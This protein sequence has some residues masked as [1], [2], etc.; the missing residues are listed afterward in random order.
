M[1]TERQ[2]IDD[3][4]DPDIVTDPNVQKVVVYCIKTCSTCKTAMKELEEAGYGVRY[5]DV[6]GQDMGLEDW[7]HLE[8][9]VG[10][11]ALVNTK[12]QTWRNL[13]EA[14][15]SGLNRDTAIELLVQKPTLMKRPAIDCGN[16]V[17]LGWTADAKREFDLA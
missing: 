11:E 17:V 14:S 9:Q 10:W 5:K 7:Q 3:Q 4:I 6:R 1:S 12:S 15:K 16:K 8:E 2:T 13:D